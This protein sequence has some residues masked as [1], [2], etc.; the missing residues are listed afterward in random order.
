[1]IF[2]K[3]SRLFYL[4]FFLGSLHVLADEK[5]D[6]VVWTAG[7]V[8]SARALFGPDTNVTVLSGAQEARH[9]RRAGHLPPAERD[10]LF[11]KVGI[12]MKISNM[13][14]FDKDILMMSAREYN[15]RELH[16][17]YPMLTESQLLHLQREMKKVK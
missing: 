2:K 5:P 7:S 12:E 16:A 1:M 17:D 13:D 11:R 4:C 14:E 9:E 3:W 10:T 6:A 15:V 8:S